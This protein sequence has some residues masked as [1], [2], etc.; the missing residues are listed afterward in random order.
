MAAGLLGKAALTADT[1]SV[2][3][4][5]PTEVVYADISFLCLNPTGTPAQLEVYVGPSAAGGASEDYIEKGIQIPANGG[6]LERSNV[7]CN[8]GEKVVF[9]VSQSGVTVRVMGVEKVTA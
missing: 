6:V 2:L 7:L 3:Y 9:K 1:L 8:P 5:V 4:T